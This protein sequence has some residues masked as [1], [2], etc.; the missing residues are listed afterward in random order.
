MAEVSKPFVITPAAVQPET[1]G[2]RSAALVRAARGGDADAFAL[3][4]EMYGP[5]V[6]AVLLSKVPLGSAEDLVHD[7]F[8]VALSRLEQLQDPEAFAGWL[9]A[10]AR[11]RALDFLRRERR[12]LPLDED[13]APGS[14]EM[15]RASEVREVLAM[16][17]ELPEAYS[18]TLLMRFVEGMTG[19]EIAART[20]LTEGSVR[21]NL[22][23]GMKLLRAKLK[24]RGTHV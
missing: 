21:V 7:V 22:S 9:M 10:I 13:A 18:E 24:L 3:L 16:L 17:R 8:E 5:A 6:H 11:H 14:T 23:R 2:E 20:G 1:L 15:P 19:P 4:Y 12:H